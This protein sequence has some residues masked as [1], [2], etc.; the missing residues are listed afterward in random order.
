MRRSG[1]VKL[2]NSRPELLVTK[3]HD[4]LGIENLVR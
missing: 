4:P 2:R 1:E 3:L